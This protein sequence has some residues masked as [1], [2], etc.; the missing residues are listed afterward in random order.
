MVTR[1][2]LKQFIKESLKQTKDFSVVNDIPIDPDDLDTNGEIDKNF[3]KYD[4][5]QEFDDDLLKDKCKSMDEFC[6]AG[7]GAIQGSLSTTNNR[8][9]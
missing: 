5:T 3:D 4:A 1:S 2:L 9:K 7:S 8:K 6:S